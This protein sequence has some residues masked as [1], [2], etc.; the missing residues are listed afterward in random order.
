MKWTKKMGE[1]SGPIEITKAKN[2]NYI[3][4]ETSFSDLRG[5]GSYQMEA[6]STESIRRGDLFLETIVFYNNS[7]SKLKEK[8]KN[9]G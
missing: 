5:R 9:M 7:I 4:R 3:I 8:A 6:I 1:F 2:F